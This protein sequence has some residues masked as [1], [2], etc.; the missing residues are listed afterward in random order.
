MELILTKDDLIDKCNPKDISS[1]RNLTLDILTRMTKVTFI[2]NDVTI[3]FKDKCS[4]LSK[5][6]VSYYDPFEDKF[7]CNW[8][9]DK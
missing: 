7:V 8:L 5:T 9:G 2:D 1:Y 3:I 4:G 6:K